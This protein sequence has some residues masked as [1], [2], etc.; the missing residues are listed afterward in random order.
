MCVCAC[1]C[2]KE[3]EREVCGER[4]KVRCRKG[5]PPFQHQLFIEGNSKNVCK[6]LKPRKQF[7]RHFEIAAKKME[8]ILQKILKEAS[9]EKY[10][11]ISV[12]AH[13]ANGEKF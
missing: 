6:H 8:D 11:H 1:V 10:A 7:L 13:K 2:A 9:S 4:R 3:R 5:P 12:K